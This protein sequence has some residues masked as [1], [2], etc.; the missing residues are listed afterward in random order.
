[1]DIN[2]CCHFRKFSS[3]VFQAIVD[4][5]EQSRLFIDSLHWGIWSFL[6]YCWSFYT[7][8]VGFQ[9]IRWV[10]HPLRWIFEYF[11]HFLRLLHLTRLNCDKTIKK[12]SENPWYTMYSHEFPWI[13]SLLCSS[14]VRQTSPQS[15]AY[16]RMVNRSHYPPAEHLM[17]QYVHNFVITITARSITINRLK[18]T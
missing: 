1:M 2:A 14:C 18:Q 11:I 9:P 17:C 6:R 7:N 13:S 3:G 15:L 16:V 12:S 4:C 10:F 8:L 5:F